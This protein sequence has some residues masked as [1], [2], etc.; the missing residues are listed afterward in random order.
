MGIQGQHV[1]GSRSMNDK[2]RR[3]MFYVFK[4]RDLLKENLVNATELHRLYEMGALVSAMGL[5]ED[6]VR[7]MEEIQEMAKAMDEAP[8]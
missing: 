4:I 5:L 3:K 6:Q 2:T 1:Q 8:E 7:I